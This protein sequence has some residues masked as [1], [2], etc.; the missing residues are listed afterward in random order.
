MIPLEHWNTGTS[1]SFANKQSVVMIL[2]V[3]D[4]NVRQGRFLRKSMGLVAI[5]TEL[6]ILFPGFCGQRVAAVKEVMA[7]KGRKV[8]V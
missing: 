5:V 1:C 6:G 3:E 4:M 7:P 8:Y 2:M